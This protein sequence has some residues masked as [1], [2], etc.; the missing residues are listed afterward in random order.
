MIADKLVFNKL[1]ERTGGRIR[2]FVS[3]GAALPPEVGTF[4]LSAGISILEGYGLTETSPVMSC[5]RVGEE[6]I[7]T[8]GQVINGVTVG[9]QRM[10]DNKIIAQV[11]GEDYPTRSEERRVGKNDGS[12]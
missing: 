10:D 6:V 11:R 3:G 9:I 12:G 4:F 2:F 1:K 8:V 5:N 7:G